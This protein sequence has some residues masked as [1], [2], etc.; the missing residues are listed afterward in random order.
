MIII[1]VIGTSSG[2]GKTHFIT[3]AIKLLKIHLN[4]E[5]AVIKNIHKHEIDEKGKDSYKYCEAGAVYSIT[6]NVNN[7]NTIFLKKEIEIDELINWLEQGP[8][9][10]D[11]FFIEGFKNLN[12]PSILCVKEYDEIENQLEKNI[13][14]ISGLICNKNIVE[15]REVK[16]PIINIEKEFERFLKIFNIK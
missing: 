7:E 16:I 13:K 14:M 2:T 6:K 4:Y 9:K 10:I 5:T 12:Y 8:F 15:T 3:N 11:L 1:R